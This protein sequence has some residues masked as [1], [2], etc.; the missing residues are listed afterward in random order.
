[1]PYIDNLKNFTDWYRQLWAESLGK[2]DFG[3]VPINSMGTVDQHS[4]LQLYL[5]GPKD[6]FFTFITAKNHANDFKI[7]DLPSCKTLF[8]GKKLSEIVKIEQETTIEVL[9]Q[10]K[11]PIR[12]FE[13]KVF[14][15]EVLGGLMM[16][17]FLET[18]LIAYVKKINPFDQP[19]VELR[20]DLAKKLLGKE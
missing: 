9:H 17:M 1:M 18:I 10:K 8:G 13:T 2:N 5:E 11:L 12:I 19:A 15:E 16:Q 7:K 20:K 14:D 3:S 4:Q 6:K